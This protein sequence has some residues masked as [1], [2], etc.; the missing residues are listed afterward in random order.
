MVDDPTLPSGVQVRLAS[1]EVATR[2]AEQVAVHCCTL[3]ACVIAKLGQVI[4]TSHALVCVCVCACVR[5]CVCVHVC[6][7]VCVCVDGIEL[8]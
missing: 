5:A 6:V 8:S 4:H 2:L 7:R 1:E 3:L